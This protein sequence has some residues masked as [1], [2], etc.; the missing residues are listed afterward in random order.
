MDID[1]RSTV[2]TDTQA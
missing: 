1:E 2:I